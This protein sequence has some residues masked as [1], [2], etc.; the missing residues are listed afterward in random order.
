MKSVW[1]YNYKYFVVKSFSDCQILFSVVPL[2]ENE[3]MN[4]F[5]DMLVPKDQEPTLVFLM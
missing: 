4:R 3:Q 5:P 2:K 1:F